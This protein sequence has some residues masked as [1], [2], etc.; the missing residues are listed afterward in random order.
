MHPWQLGLLA[1]RTLTNILLLVA[2]EVLND[3]FLKYD[4][5]NTM[6]HSLVLTHSFSQ[7]KNIL[8]KTCCKIS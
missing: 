7:I 5:P 6:N 8:E 4:F 2:A 3:I 1:C